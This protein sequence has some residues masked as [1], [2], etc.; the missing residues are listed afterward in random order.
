MDIE[1]RVRRLVTKNAL[2]TRIIL[3]YRKYHPTGP[4]GFTTNAFTVD[5]VPRPVPAPYFP[6]LLD[7][8]RFMASVIFYNSLILYVLAIYLIWYSPVL[9]TVP[10][11]LV[12]FAAFMCRKAGLGSGNFT[13]GS[14]LSS[15]GHYQASLL[16]NS[17]PS[18]DSA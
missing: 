14:L 3:W 15:I 10:I 1:S 9:I 17:N 2:I 6:I 8:W 12:H 16:Q 5:G 7:S 4:H 18:Q 11:A 13:A